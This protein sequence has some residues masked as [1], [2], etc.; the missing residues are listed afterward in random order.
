MNKIG[1]K[2]YKAFISI[3]KIEN[4]GSWELE[5]E[6]EVKNEDQFYGIINQIKNQFPEFIKKFK[7]SESIK[8]IKQFIHH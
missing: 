1:Y 7:L 8:N 5:P 4:V 3:N 2:F 6:F